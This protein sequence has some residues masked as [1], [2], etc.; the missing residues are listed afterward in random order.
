MR[1]IWSLTFY[2]GRAQSPLSIAL[3]L[4]FWSLCPQ[5]TNSNC[6]VGVGAW[7]EHVSPAS[8][9]HVC[10]LSRVCLFCDPIDCSPPESSVHGILQA[11][12][13]EWV[14][15]FFSRRSSQLKDR[16]CI[17]CVGWWI[18]FPPHHPGSLMRVS[19]LA[20]CQAYEG[21]Q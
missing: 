3:L 4:I 9:R 17:S 20:Q 19:P 11:R 16:T 1:N 8:R 6:L 5:G 15:I 18:L 14:A 13:R 12:I 2:L 7:G 10:V 21:S